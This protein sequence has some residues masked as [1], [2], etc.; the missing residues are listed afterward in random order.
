MKDI[1]ES[2]RRNELFRGIELEDFSKVCGS[3]SF[4]AVHY[5]KEEPVMLC[6]DDVTFF[7][8]ILSGGIKI[9]KEDERGNTSMLTELSA[10]DTFGEVLVCAAIPVSPVTVI[11]RTE[12]DILQIGSRNIMNLCD[13]A[14]PFHRQ[15][16]ENL[17]HIVAKKNFA[18]NRKIEILS[19]RSTREKIL[20]FLDYYGKGRKAFT[21]PFNREEMA[22]YLCVD[23]SAMSAELCRMRDR[24]LIRF[25]RN[26]FEI[27]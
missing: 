2:M 18:L 26:R 27:L 21:V 10:P 14:C 23:R 15:F 22:H 3:L 16:I 8:L 19:Q 12:T 24:E 4:K 11:A 17:L 5:K 9:V 6:G 20:A 25:D 1:F 7:G 13:K